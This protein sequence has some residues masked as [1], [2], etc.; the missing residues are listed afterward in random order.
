M[1]TA[2]ITWRTQ[3]QLLLLGAVGFL[4]C[5]A[6]TAYAEEQDNKREI[7]SYSEAYNKNRA[8]FTLLNCQYV[9]R[10]YPTGTKIEDVIQGKAKPN[11]S[12]ECI[13]LRDGKKCR[14]EHALSAEAVKRSLENMGTPFPPKKVLIDGE[15]GIWYSSILKGG[16]LMT[17]A[18]Q[19]DPLPTSPFDVNDFPQLQSDLNPLSSLFNKDIKFDIHEI[20]ALASANF[21]NRH[22]LPLKYMEYS[23]DRIKFQFGIAPGLGCLPIVAL[24]ILDGDVIEIANILEF[25]QLDQDR[26]F[27]L[28][29]INTYFTKGKVKFIRETQVLALKLNEPIDASQFAIDTSEMKVIRDTADDASQTRIS[30][31]KISCD[32]FKELLEITRAAAEKERAK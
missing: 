21:E 31:E 4:A 3:S 13:L 30:K 22:K 20:T 27:P 11:E 15:I 10:S 24:V 19:H 5:F 7:H 12:A 2:S 23:S 28:H 26:A 25:K 16:V 32:D 29:S 17:A 8:S 1:T 14:I 18:A 9:M 6:G